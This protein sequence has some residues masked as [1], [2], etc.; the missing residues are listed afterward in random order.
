MATDTLLRD[1]VRARAHTHKH[2]TAQHNTLH[3]H[4]TL[5]HTCGPRHRR[6][7]TWPHRAGGRGCVS[8]RGC[9]SPAARVRASRR[10]CSAAST[11]VSIGVA[12]HCDA[13]RDANGDAERRRGVRRRREASARRVAAAASQAPSPGAPRLR[14]GGRRRSEAVRRTTSRRRPS[15][16]RRG[17]GGTVC[18]QVVRSRH[19]ILGGSADSA[20]SAARVGGGRPA[21]FVEVVCPPERA[22]SRPSERRLG[23]PAAPCRGAGVEGT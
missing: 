13:D 11:S 16:N 7:S 1:A 12:I 3:T 4:S 22:A 2:N 10:P 9:P 14:A 15:G 19:A 23:V 17:E 6:R 18:S 5:R 21:A 8:G 20:H